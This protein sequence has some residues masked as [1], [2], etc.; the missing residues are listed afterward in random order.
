MRSA[1]PAGRANRTASSHVS[2]RASNSQLPLKFREQGHQTQH[3]DKLVSCLLYNLQAPRLYINCC[4]MV[5][6]LVFFILV[7]GTFTVI[8]QHRL[9]LP[10]S[11]KRVAQTT[12]PHM[13]YA[14]KPGAAG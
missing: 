7:I 1:G 12:L 6:V 9:F 14:H 5:Q 2:R 13:A 8:I 10:V 11:P 3:H 4:S